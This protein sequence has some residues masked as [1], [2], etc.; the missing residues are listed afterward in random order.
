[1]HS[2]SNK[3]TNPFA[4]KKSIILI[5]TESINPR[6][7]EMRL[8]RTLLRARVSNFTFR[9]NDTDTRPIAS[10]HIGR[11]VDTTPHSIKPNNETRTAHN[12]REK[13]A[14]QQ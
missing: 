3:K 1:M 14:E 8:A 9:V 6:L 11:A 10:H 4:K 13:P 2:R 5:A 7:L 12:W